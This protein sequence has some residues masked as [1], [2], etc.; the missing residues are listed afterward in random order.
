MKIE[1]LNIALYRG[2]G[3][4]S[5]DWWLE[6]LTFDNGTDSASLL[7]VGRNDGKWE[8]DILWLSMVARWLENRA[9]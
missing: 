3:I 7:L 4:H 8:A 6:V 1:F 5:T 2:H 9:K